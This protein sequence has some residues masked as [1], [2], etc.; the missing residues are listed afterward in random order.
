MLALVLRVLVGVPFKARNLRLPLPR[1]WPL[2]HIYIWLPVLGAPSPCPKPNHPKAQSHGPRPRPAVGS[3][4]RPPDD[5]EPCTRQQTVNGEYRPA[6]EVVGSPKQEAR[7]IAGLLD[8]ITAADAQFALRIRL[9]PRPARP[10]PSSASVPGSGVGIGVVE[11]VTSYMS[12]YSLKKLGNSIGSGK[13][14]PR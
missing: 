12:S 7:H 3:T 8:R 4:F 13:Y 9:R 14:M 5:P 1:M 6:A 2:R 10:R 11:I